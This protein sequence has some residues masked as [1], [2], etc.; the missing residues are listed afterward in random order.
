MRAALQSI[1]DRLDRFGILISS[2]CVVHCLAGLIV[3]S[4]LGLGGEFILAP[5]WHRFGLAIAIGVGIVTI[6]LGVLRHGK[7]MPLALAVVG[8]SLMTTGLFVSHGFQ[9]AA[10]TVP[11]VLLVA[12]AHL[13]NL[14]HAL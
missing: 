4:V 13:L 12:A 5:Q 7:M 9:E 14:R 8:L 6:G 10:F 3:V 2:L 11:G 1:R